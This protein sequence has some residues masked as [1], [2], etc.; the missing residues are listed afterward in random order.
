MTDLEKTKYSKLAD[1]DDDDPALKAA[2]SK[3]DKVVILK[4]MFTLKELKVRL[5][6]P[7]ASK[8]ITNLLGGSYDAT[9]SKAGHSRGV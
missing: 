6:C 2:A 9:G 8:M 1:W 5:L 4:H 3:W 7:R